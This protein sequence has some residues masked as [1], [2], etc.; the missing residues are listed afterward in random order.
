[1]KY[2]GVFCSANDLEEKYTQPVKE[3]A[4]LMTAHS[5]NLVWGGSDRGLMKTIA[6]A[7]QDGGGKLIGVTIEIFNKV[8]RKNADEIILASSLGERKETILARSDAIVVLV[9][10]IGTLDELGEMLEL[11][12]QRKHNKPIVVL[13]TD[14]FYEGVKVQL[15][16]MKDD[17][18]INRPLE[19]LIYFA[20]SPLEA[21]EYINKN[22]D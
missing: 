6:S 1:M 19:D 4:K 18:F 16:K 13:N 8:S 17:G 2:I 20:D 14:N 7:V 15:Q 5:Y 10:G 11:K 9:G 22:V 12:K 21:I 3:F